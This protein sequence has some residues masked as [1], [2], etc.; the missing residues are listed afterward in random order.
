VTFNA[1]QGQ[2]YEIQVGSAGPTRGTINGTITQI[3]ANPG[4]GPGPGPG[5]SPGP[6]PGPTASFGRTA[7]VLQ[8]T[9][10]V[11]IIIDGRSVALGASTSL[12]LGSVVDARGGTIVIN[13]AGGQSVTLSQGMFQVTQNA[14]GNN[15][16]LQTPP[17]RARACA[18]RPPKGA[19]R[20]LGGT[21]KGTFRVLGAAATA[22]VRN[23]VFR[24]QDTCKG[25]KVTNVKGTMTVLAKGSRRTK[26]IRPGRTYVIKA[27]LFG[28]R[29]RR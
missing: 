27:R 29:R 19:V 20:Q 4:P 15:V 6:S 23:G 11:F 2:R 24:V 14:A 26:T 13:V 5:P 8:V 12:A 28:A 21:A 10:T 22:T 17:G 25:T 18:R 3:A 16:A 9:G 7:V 1:S